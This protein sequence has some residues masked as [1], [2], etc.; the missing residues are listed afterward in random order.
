MVSQTSKILPDDGLDLDFCC[1]GTPESIAMG[2]WLSATMLLM[3][4][5]Q[6]SQSLVRFT[7]YPHFPDEDSEAKW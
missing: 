6:S 1:P 3:H 7:L 4:Q 5:L 2:R